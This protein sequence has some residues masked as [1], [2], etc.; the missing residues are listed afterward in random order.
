MDAETFARLAARRQKS[1]SRHAPTAALRRELARLGIALY[2]L[3][4][5]RA[6]THQLTHVPLVAHAPKDAETPCFG[7]P[8]V[9][10]YRPRASCE[11]R[12]LSRVILAH[13]LVRRGLIRIS[14]PQL[15][16]RRD[17]I[18]VGPDFSQAAE[19]AHDK[20]AETARLRK[21]LADLGIDP[22][23]E[24]LPEGMTLSPPG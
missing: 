1:D 8:C 5:W 15:A 18:P 24:S 6:F 11:A 19:S 10:Q 13:L 7:D 2:T 4:A 21:D 3:P 22:A 9:N 17:L 14:W 23:A 12:D 16:R 20:L